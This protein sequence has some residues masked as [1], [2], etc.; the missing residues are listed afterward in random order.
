V[1]ERI[2]LPA[3][4]LEA[5]QTEVLPG[6]HIFLVPGHTWGQQ[7]I[8]F[9]DDRGRRVVF[10]PDIMPTVH[11]VGSTYNLAYDVEP[12]MSTVNRHWF[13]REAAARNW[14][15][16]LDHEPGNPC[17]TVRAEGDWFSLVPAEI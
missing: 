15:L 7:A 4:P 6:I 5:R 1:P 10:T 13:L 12:Y 8:L 2:E 9:T 3:E 11:H 16:V 14:L 17:C